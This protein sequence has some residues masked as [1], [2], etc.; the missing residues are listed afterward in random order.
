MNTACHRLVGA[1]SLESRVPPSLA[2]DVSIMNLVAAT[3][4]NCSVLDNQVDV[5][6]SEAAFC[7]P[8]SCMIGV[9]S[10]SIGLL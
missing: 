2:C 10:F 3:V 1:Q 9:V 4:S 8:G 6:A 7:H 5:F